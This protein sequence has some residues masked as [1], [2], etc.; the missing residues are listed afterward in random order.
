[1]GIAADFS[2]DDLFSSQNVPGVSNRLLIKDIEINKIQTS[3]III[4]LILFMILG[5]ESLFLHNLK[6]SEAFTPLAERKDPKQVIE[7]YSKSLDA[8]LIA[9]ERE[10]PLSIIGCLAASL[11]EN[12]R[13]ESIETELVRSHSLLFRG[14]LTS[15]NIN[16]FSSSLKSLVDKLNI[17]FELSNPISI[18]DVEIEKERKGSENGRQNYNISFH[19]DLT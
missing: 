13:I 6:E 12:I 2:P 16:D 11:P 17:N 15:K 14:T 10:E 19:L 3:G 18:D 8:L 1:M 7:Q 4:G 9:T 5:M